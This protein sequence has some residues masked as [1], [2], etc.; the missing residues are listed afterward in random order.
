MMHH[1][2]D[3]KKTT[4]RRLRDWDANLGIQL[5]HSHEVER[6][7]RVSSGSDEVEASVSATVVIRVQAPFDLQFLLEIS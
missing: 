5:L 6:F 1:F 3:A 4:S 2:T 7:E